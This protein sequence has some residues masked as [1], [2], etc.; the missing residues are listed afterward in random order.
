MLTILGE[1]SR[2]VGRREVEAVGGGVFHRLQDER[3]ASTHR[4]LGDGQAVTYDTLMDQT[5]I[6]RLTMSLELDHVQRILR[7]KLVGPLTG[8]LA[9]IIGLVVG[10]RTYL[11]PLLAF[12]LHCVCNEARQ[13]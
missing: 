2:N 13:Q 7:I 1:P 10:R 11:L 3:C 4:L 5:F 8:L 9:C 12:F 6:Y